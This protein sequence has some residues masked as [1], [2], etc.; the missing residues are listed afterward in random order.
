MAEAPIRRVDKRDWTLPASHAD[1][2]RPVVS[3]PNDPHSARTVISAPDCDRTA[4][5]DAAS[6]IDTASVSDVSTCGTDCGS[7]RTEHGWFIVAPEER[8]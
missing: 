4:G 1:H 8:R 3:A 5:A 2:P 7:S 6:S